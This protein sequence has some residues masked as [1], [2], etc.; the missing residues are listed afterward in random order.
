MDSFKTI[1]LIFLILTVV[2]LG[3][4]EHRLS[5]AIPG[6]GQLVAYDDHGEIALPTKKSDYFG[7]DANNNLLPTK[8]LDNEDGTVSDLV[9]GLTWTKK[10]GT[11]MTIAEAHIALRELNKRGSSDWRIPNVKELYSL[12][13]YSGQVFG[14]KS[15]RLFIDTQFFE[16]PIGSV[17]TREREIDAQVWSSTAFKGITMGRDQSQFG[18]NFVDGRVKAYPLYDPRTGSPNRMYF[19]FVR[20]NPEYGKNNFKDN[21]DDTISDLA[22]GLMW[23]KNDSQRGMTWKEALVYS[24]NQVTGGFDDW[25]MPS[26]KEL[27]SLVDYTI[28]YQLTGKPASSSFFNFS[29]ISR[30]DQKMDV[31]YYWTGTT[32]LDGPS[33]GSM[34]VY[35]VFGTAMAKPSDLLVDA[36]GSGA[37]RAD[38]KFNDSK[39]GKPVY[40]GPQGDLQIVF[41]FVRCVRT[42]NQY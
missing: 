27:Q 2:N 10:L 7:Q 25:R 11:K 28:S 9:T 41:N 4:E 30:P 1:A 5:Y 23:Q 20:G 8:Y 32:L 42:I 22:T 3:A 40:F 18:V 36:H 16:Q 17:S 21:G 14:D 37:V 29:Q 26:A 13:L 38:P 24:Q 12:V 39:D 34:A 15:V 19:R 35:V 33:P 31:P 6:T